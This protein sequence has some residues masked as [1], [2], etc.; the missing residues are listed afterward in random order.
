VTPG[1]VSGRPLWDV[2]NNFVVPVLARRGLLLVTLLVED[3]RSGDQVIARY[4]DL[5][6]LQWMRSDFTDPNPVATLGDA[7]SYASR[8]YECEQSGPDQIDWVIERLRMNPSLRSATIITFQPLSDTSYIHCVGVPDFYSHRRRL[9]LAVFASSFYFGTKDFVNLAIPAYVQQRVGEGI[10]AELGSL[11]MIVNL[12][13]VYH[14]DV[15][16]RNDVL[17]ATDETAQ[18]F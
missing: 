15:D 10:T 11:T 12:A 18:E 16:E 1:Q 5:E 3:P 9:E 7:E 4:E 6:R 8:R 17:F 14:G 2:R 13:H